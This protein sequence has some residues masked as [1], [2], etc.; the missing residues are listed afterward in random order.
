MLHKNRSFWPLWVFFWV[1]ERET[2]YFPKFFD[3][4]AVSSFTD[5]AQLTLVFRCIY[6]NLLRFLQ[7][8]LTHIKSQLKLFNRSKSCVSSIL[9]FIQKYSRWTKT[10]SKDWRSEHLQNHNIWIIPQ[11]HDNTWQLPILISH[12][13]QFIVFAWRK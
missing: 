9:K 7:T 10:W 1:R 5:E 6:D 12:E 3:F 11:I 4:L 2:V 13:L 8:C